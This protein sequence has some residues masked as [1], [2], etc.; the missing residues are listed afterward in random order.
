MTTTTT[1]TRAI[2]VALLLALVAS[3]CGIVGD[4]GPYEIDVEFARTYNLF[5]G[6][7]VR[8]LGVD[9][10][11]VTDLSIE[12]GSDVVTVTIEV[13]GDVD[14]PADA[15]AVI[16]PEALLGERYVQLEPAYTDGETLA[17]GATIPVDRTVVPFEFDEI[18]DNLNQF[19]GG[20]D[21]P[22]V[23]RLFDNLATTLDG[24][25]EEIGRTID[26]AHEAIEVLADNDEELVSLASRLADLNTTLATRDQA[27]GDILEDWNTVTSTLASERTDLDGALNGLVRVTEQ[28]GGLLRTHRASL[29]SDIETLTRVGRTSNRNLDNLSLL[30]LSSAELFRHAERVI[31]R[32]RNMLPLQNHSEEL[33]GE[34]ARSIEAR[35][36]GLCA[37]SGL[38]QD[39]CD[40]IPVGDLVGSALCLEPLVPCP[41]DGS[42]KTVTEAVRDVL[43]A[44]PE[45]RQAIR[46]S[47]P[48]APPSEDDEDLVSRTADRLLGSASR[49][50][51]DAR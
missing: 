1:R 33:G 41:D 8:V 15:G 20:L 2:A 42:K 37:R 38:P 29:E 45:L 43:A 39:Q 40:E 14:L 23:G 22:E 34:L 35:L 16:V 7:P 3:A 36:E 46:D 6:S 47:D 11:R 32:E 51:G 31:D 28:L 19:V 10:G 12:P 26:Q 25:G 18:L 49:E 50:G 5:P 13:D 48:E 17:A 4:D 30:I 44:S 27:I 9:V 24:N 21:A